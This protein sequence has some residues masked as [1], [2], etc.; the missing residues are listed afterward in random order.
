VN[1]AAAPAGA[2]G[3]SSPAQG[4]ER[5]IAQQLEMMTRQLCCCVRVQWSAAVAALEPPRRASMPSRRRGRP[6]FR[7]AAA[8]AYVAYQSIQKAQ[9]G[10]LSERQREHVDRL[11]ARLTAKTPGSKRLAATHRGHWADSTNSAKF[12]CPGRRSAPLVAERAGS[13]MWD[14]DGNSTW[15][16][17][18]LRL[19]ALRPLSLLRGGVVRRQMEA[20]AEVGPQSPLPGEVA[21]LITELTGTER[22]AFCNSGTEPS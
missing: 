7:R 18:G 9:G 16:S 15:T 21:R 20:G 11:I 1:L 13:R 12:R 17:H 14:V 8:E 5:I 19:A 10:A 4:I 22:V 3:V 6:R 2:A